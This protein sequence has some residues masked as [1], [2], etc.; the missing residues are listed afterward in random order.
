MPQTPPPLVL[1]SASPARLALL[2]RAG[3][4]PRVVVSGIDEEALEAALGPDATPGEV[5]LVLAQAKARAVAVLDDT[6]GALVVGCDSV[7]E[8]EGRTLGKPESVEEAV[9]R[10]YAMRGRSGVLLTGHWLVDRST[11]KEIGE[12]AATTVH[13]GEPSDEEVFAYVATG[14]PLQVAGA[15]T[16][17][18]IGGAFIDG[19]DGDHSNVVGLS[20]PL[21]RKLITELGHSYAGYWTA[22]A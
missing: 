10:W 4:T 6:E 9:A 3:L 13:F 16:I 7:L 17:D 8:F 11:G 20:K 14:E 21:L 18:G 22:G 1:A 12:V 2:T 15:F 5:A 19:I